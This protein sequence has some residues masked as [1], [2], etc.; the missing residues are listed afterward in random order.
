[1]L[2]IFIGR[3]IINSIYVHVHIECACVPKRHL[4]CDVNVV[5]VIAIQKVCSI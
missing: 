1:M 3:C 5:K 4:E 2:F